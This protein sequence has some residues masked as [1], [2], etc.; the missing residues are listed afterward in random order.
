M[1]KKNILIILSVI[2][3]F[4]AIV[5]VFRYEDQ[6][7]V[8]AENKAQQIQ[9]ENNRK[10]AKAEAEKKIE[11]QK[12]KEEAAAE[13]KKKQMDDKYEEGKKL[14]LNKE[15]LNAISVADELIKED[16]QYYQ[17]YNLKGIAL[18]YYGTGFGGE[19]FTQ[20]MKNIDK[21]LE[22]KPDYGYGMFNKALAYELYAKYD[23]AI[24]WYN[25]SL[26]VEKYEWSYYGLASIYGRKG[27]V[28]NSVKYLKLAI[29]MNSNIKDDAK[30][31]P[32]FNNVR[33][34]QEF[35]DAIK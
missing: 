30:T 23:D 6:K 13:A 19:N 21:S 11:E 29:A 31:E 7:K 28:E 10:K 24:E 18:C 4:I 17:A 9:A 27:D 34:S 14:F 2:I 20:G 22:I 26:T 5:F 1:K 32:D 8:E 16:P 35:Q 25:K 33:S 12:K 3:V 15:Y